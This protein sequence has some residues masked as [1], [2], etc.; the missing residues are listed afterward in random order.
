MRK[1]I[2]KRLAAALSAVVMV[3]SVC[4]NGMPASANETGTGTADITLTTAPE[5]DF[6]NWTFSDLGIAD[7]TLTDNSLWDNKW[8]NGNSLD[9]TI[10]SGKINFAAD[11]TN[12][13]NFYIGGNGNDGSKWRGFVFTANG[14][15][16]KL[17]FAFAGTGGNFFNADGDTGSGSSTGAIATFDPAVAGTTLRGNSD[18]KLA[19]SVEY[20]SVADGNVTMKVG[21]FFDGVLY[22]NTYYTVKDVPEDYLKQ[23]LRFYPVGKMN[24]VA[25]CGLNVEQ[26]TLDTAPEKDF[27]SWTFSD[28]GIADQTLTD[29]SLWDNKWTNGKSLDKTI[30]HGKI[31]FVSKNEDYGFGQF[32]IGGAAKTDASKY[33]G[34]LLHANKSF[35]TITFAFL[36][37][38]GYLYNESGSTGSG[39]MA[40]A[41]AVFDPAKA[42][43]QLQGNDDLQVSLSVEYIAVTDGKVTLKVGVFF[44]GRLYDNTYYTVKDVPEEYLNQAVR[45]NPAGTSNSIASC[46]TDITLRNAPEKDFTYWSFSDVGIKDQTVVDTNLWSNTLTN[47]KSIDQTIFNGKVNFAETSSAAKTWDFGQLFIG[48]VDPAGTTGTKYC[49]FLFEANGSTETLTFGFYV[50][51]AYYGADGT[52]YASVNQGKL[53]VFDAETAGIALRGNKDLQLSMSFEYADQTEDGKVTLKVGVFFDGKLYNN[54]YYTVPN[55]PEAYLKQAVRFKAQTDTDNRVASLQKEVNVAAASNGTTVITSH[56]NGEAENAGY[57]AAALNDGMAGQTAPYYLGATGADLQNEPMTLEFTFDN[58][59]TID[60]VRMYKRTDAGGFPVNFVLDVYTAEGWKT[61]VS[62]SD[63]LSVFGW[64]EFIFDDVTCSAVRLKTTKVARHQGGDTYGL[65]LAEFEA[66]GTASTAEIPTP[67]AMTQEAVALAY[68]TNIQMIFEHPIMA[69]G[70]CLY[71]EEAG[72]F[73]GELAVYAFTGSQW[74]QVYAES[75]YTPN[76]ARTAHEFNF[77]A[78]VSCSSIMVVAEGQSETSEGNVLQQSGMRV[79]GYSGGDCVLLGDAD[80][81]EELTAAEDLAAM[82]KALTA[83]ADALTNLDMNRDGVVNVCDLVRMKHYFAE[84]EKKTSDISCMTFNV[85][86]VQKDGYEDPAVRA[87]KIAN[88]IL[89]EK[90]DLAGIQEAGHNGTDYDWTDGFC[91]MVCQDET[92]AAVKIGDDADYRKNSTHY[93]K[94]GQVSNSAGLIILYK[95]ARFELLESGV[96]AY[97]STESQERWFQWVKLR[98]KKTDEVV[99]MTNTHWSVDLNQNGTADTEAGDEHRTKQA[100]ELLAFWQDTVGENLLFATGDY[101]C[102]SSSKWLTALGSGNYKE[103]DAAIARAA[104]LERHIEHVFVNAKEVTVKACHFSENCD[105]SYSD[106]MPLITKVSY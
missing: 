106:H 25:S 49:G 98:D 97:T 47:G 78:P 18:L 94:Y 19:L 8:T 101:N 33:R 43:T 64:N 23:S 40:G 5:K 76:A 55:V 57:G 22:D 28:V 7:Q 67:A 4:L 29:N 37:A 41:L 62:Q 84:A 56:F 66:Y 17:M 86:G 35:E 103:A 72:S 42:G 89:E 83:P 36:G 58:A 3:C 38:D 82:R 73:P 54:T 77:D 27:A 92:Y 105:P 65:H 70:V 2:L 60:S 6:T 71:T 88:Y 80:E 104:S 69:D 68:D 50:N 91:R 12:F 81:N 46:S 53:A 90:V 100:N 26:I 10:F 44:D 48:A 20:V 99:F 1:S 61:V 34:F 75:A 39:A 9:K 93:Q 59:Y 63:Y 11:T 95:T 16:D 74:E 31:K 79:N 14:T 13:G 24:E 51:G 15:T 45:F 87:P 102:D 32:Y 30:F 85:L 21:V 52:T 96:Q